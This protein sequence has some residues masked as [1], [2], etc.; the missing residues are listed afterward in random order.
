MHIWSYLIIFVLKIIENGLG[1]I[2]TIFIA[3][4]RKIIG[5]FLNFA[6]A[7]TWIISTGMVVIDIKQDPIRVLVFAFGCFIGSYLGSILEEKI[8]LGNNIIMCITN[9][10]ISDELR[11]NGYSITTTNG[12]GMKDNKFVL[13]IAI[14][15]RS[16]KNLTKKIIELDPNSMI[17][18][19]CA[20]IIY[21]GS[22]I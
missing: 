8:A 16:K 13:F 7:I 2:R 6:I 18:S 22:N 11:K 19:E 20:T 9:I 12:Y 17:I 21:G 3:N 14:T 15:R 1:T 4:G 10:D 5:A